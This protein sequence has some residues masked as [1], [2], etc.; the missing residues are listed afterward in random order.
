MRDANIGGPNEYGGWYDENELF[1]R[2]ILK[3]W[4][5]WVFHLII[6]SII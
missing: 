1:D 5:L 2:I 3:L 4:F 6:F